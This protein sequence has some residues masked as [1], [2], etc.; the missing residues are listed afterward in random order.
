MV[1]E[2]AVDIAA[3]PELALYDMAALSVIVEE[4]G[5][6]FTS[7]S[8]QE[9]PHGG[10]ALSSNARLHDQALA[11]IGELPDE[12]GSREEEPDGDGGSVHDLHAGRPS[13]PTADWPTRNERYPRCGVERGRLSR[14]SSQGATTSAARSNQP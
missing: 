1:A 8:G 9:G 3:E 4:A 13:H 14:A 5:G 11:L 7:L 2:G 10:N 12:T 6:Q